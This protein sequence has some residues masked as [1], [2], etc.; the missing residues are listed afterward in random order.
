MSSTI[1][2]SNAE[3]VVL[4][5]LWNDAPLLSADI[6]SEVKKTND[7][8]DKTIKTLLSRLVKKGAIDYQQ[9]G[10]AYRYFPLVQQADYQQRVSSSVVDRLFSGKV[11]GLVSG[12]AQQRDLSQEDVDSLKDI[13][14]QW[15]KR[16]ESNND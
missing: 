15:E 14:A 3:L 11:S 5:V 10:R 9:V 4:D 12:F 1:D 7:W 6:V 8:H 2:I 16:Q 13:I